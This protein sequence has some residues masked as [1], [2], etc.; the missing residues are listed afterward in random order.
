MHLLF[1]A[2][3][4]G[5]EMREPIRPGSPCSNPK[6]THSTGGQ[7]QV[8]RRELMNE[9]SR[10][11]TALLIITASTGQAL[12]TPTVTS[13]GRRAQKRKS[14]RKHNPKRGAFNN[15]KI[16]VLM[17]FLILKQIDYIEHRFAILWKKIKL[18]CSGTIQVT[19]SL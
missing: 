15:A 5:G 17:C 16:N 4:T 18:S 7:A 2:C 8:H 19:H 11:Q 13:Q 3:K 6:P 9:H 14:S 10:N 12:H 1:K